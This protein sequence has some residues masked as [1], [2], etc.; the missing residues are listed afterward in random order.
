MD[1]LKG[2][3]SSRVL[4]DKLSIGASVLKG[5]LLGSPEVERT[6]QEKASRSDGLSKE[7]VHDDREN[8]EDY[9]STIVMR[10]LWA[11]YVRE[12]ALDAEQFGLVLAALHGVYRERKEEIADTEVCTLSATALV[13]FP[14]S[15]S[16][17]HFPSHINT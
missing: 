1:K 8:M 9:D 4:K 12:G 17:P 16:S 7:S 11:D 2:K 13:L 10:N 15:S 5:I 3:L 14:A 6:S